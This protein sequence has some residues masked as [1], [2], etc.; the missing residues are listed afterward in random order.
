MRVVF[1]I[2]GSFFL[3]LVEIYKER[4][5]L[6]RDAEQLS[7]YAEMRLKSVNV[8]LDTNESLVHSIDQIF[9]D[10]FGELKPA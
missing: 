8:R 5:A 9:K 6:E 4:N 10:F 1:V 2:G 7:G 3:Q